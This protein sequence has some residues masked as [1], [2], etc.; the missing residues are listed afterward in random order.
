[1]RLVSRFGFVLEAGY[2]IV[3]IFL[4]GVCAW[5]C[6]VFSCGGSWSS[7]VSPIEASE[8]IHRLEAIRTMTNGWQGAPEIGHANL[9]ESL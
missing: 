5:V 4:F 9:R 6:A 1:M 7:A 2:T 3:S 8:D